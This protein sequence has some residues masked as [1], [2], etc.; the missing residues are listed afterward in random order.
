M[1]LADCP[2][3]GPHR[4]QVHRH[5]R[6]VGDEAA[7]GV[8]Q[9]AGEVE[10]LLDVHRVGRPLQRRPHRLGDAHEAAIVE[11]KRDGVG[12]VLGG[13]GRA[14]RCPVADQAHK[15][16]CLFDGTPT[17]RDEDLGV[18]AQYQT[19]SPLRGGGRGWGCRLRTSGV[20]TPTPNPSPQGGG[21]FAGF[22][23]DARDE[24]IA[25]WLDEAEQAPVGGLEAG[26]DG[27]QIAERDGQGGV[28]LGVAEVEADVRLPGARR[29]ARRG[30][31]PPR[32]SVDPASAAAAA[33]PATPSAAPSPAVRIDRIRAWP[34]PQAESTL[35]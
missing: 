27:R 35:A 24:D 29:P 5:V 6:G 28:G 20:S 25:L 17:G 22:R 14:R 19:P 21:G 3:A 34:M 2:H 16:V 11:L 23:L 7:A 10:P 12:L 32:A 33:T 13:R 26:A 15:T 1:A 18:G 8:E 9:R 31:L 4:A 30:R